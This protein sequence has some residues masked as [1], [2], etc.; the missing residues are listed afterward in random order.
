MGPSHGG[1]ALRMDAFENRHPEALR[2]RAAEVW[3]QSLHN[4]LV[5]A[6][7]ANKGGLRPP[8]GMGGAEPPKCRRVPRQRLMCAATER[9]RELARCRAP[10]ERRS[11]ACRFTLV[12]TGTCASITERSVGA[13]RRTMPGSV[14]SRRAV[15]G[16]FLR[17]RPW[18]WRREGRTERG[19]PEAGG[20]TQTRPAAGRPAQGAFPKPRVPK[21]SSGMLFFCS[22]LNLHRTSAH[23]LH[24]RNYCGFIAA[25]QDM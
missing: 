22:Q 5:M 3:R 15:L 10:P 21:A 12:P 24:P 6:R 17:C 9:R 8:R 7:R 11:G 16:A 14:A 25:R 13:P 1:G 4:R 2:R 20:G 18:A 23:Q 19:W